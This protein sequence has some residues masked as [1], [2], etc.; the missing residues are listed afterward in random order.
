MPRV[1]Y[2]KKGW[3]E[4]YRSVTKG[5]QGEIKNTREY[6][7]RKKGGVRGTESLLSGCGMHLLRVFLVSKIRRERERKKIKV[8]R[9]KS[10]WK[11][12]EC[13]SGRVFPRGYS[14]VA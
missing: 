13:P 9:A 11:K 8:P 4:S 14:R 12:K 5:P 3:K 10:L 1:K 6:R 7:R 2:Q